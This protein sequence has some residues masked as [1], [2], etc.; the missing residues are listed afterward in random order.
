MFGPGSIWDDLGRADI[1]LR[2]HFSFRSACCASMEKRRGYRV[3]G[4]HRSVQHKTEEEL[5]VGIHGVRY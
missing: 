2:L 1:C 5:V 3:L 4:E